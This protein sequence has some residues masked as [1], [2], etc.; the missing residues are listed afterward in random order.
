MALPKVVCLDVHGM[1]CGSCV[2]GV[3]TA[4][5]GVPGVASA[6]VRLDGGT[7]AG[8]GAATVTPAAGATVSPAALVAA[9]ATA[10]MRAVV[11]PDGGAAAGSVVDLHVGG[12][13]CGG[14]VRSITDV[15]T[16][17]DGV[18]S[19]EVSLE[20]KRATVTLASPGAVTV[21]ALVAA[22]VGAGKEAS[23]WVGG[24]VGKA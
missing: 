15:L 19:A 7:A 22:V 17:L 24:G 18:T 6:S 5:E 11:V 9:V 21:D 1:T 8:A 2:R 20:A 13:T 10:G 12:M 14:C 16:A 3:T 4:L 23:P